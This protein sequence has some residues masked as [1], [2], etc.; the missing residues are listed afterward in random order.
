MRKREHKSA[1]GWTRMATMIAVLATTCACHFASLPKGST[2]KVGPAY[3]APVRALEVEASAP[4]AADEDEMPAVAAA[5]P[6]AQPVAETIVAPAPIVSD[7]TPTAAPATRL[8]T[9]RHARTEPLPEGDV[10]NA[11]DG[12]FFRRPDRPIR[13]ALATQPVSEVER[14]HG[15]R[16]LSFHLTLEDGTEGYFKPSQS[17]NGMSWSSEI[18]AYHLDRELGFGRVAPSVGRRIAFDELEPTANT[19]ARRDELRVEE[20]GM[21]T[22]AFIWWVPERLRPVELPEGWEAWLRNDS[23][24]PV[25]TPFQRPGTY[26]TATGRRGARRAIETIPTPDRE[27]RPAELSDLIVFDYLTQNLDRWG[28][29]NTNIRTVG[30]GGELMFLDNAA[31]F[32]L[33]APRVGMMDLRLH[34]VQRFRRSTIEAIRAFDIDAY[35]ERLERDAL[36]PVLD[37]RQLENLEIRRQHVLEYVDGLIEEH[38][39]DAILVW[40]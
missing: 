17:F 30:E 5:E 15:G 12:R 29:N 25:V 39:E 32:V 34:E 36:S 1:A 27:E 2:I 21:I 20:D 26:R 4:S 13:I 28:G 38:G 31:G 22:G 24:V 16:S 6:V 19:D 8:R 14:G 7:E 10:R 3:A 23:T 33:R 40:D 9:R 11:S 35:R 18:A 37:D